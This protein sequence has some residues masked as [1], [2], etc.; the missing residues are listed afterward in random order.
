MHLSTSISS[1]IFCRLWDLWCSWYQWQGLLHHLWSLLQRGVDGAS[2]EPQHGAVGGGHGGIHAGSCARLVVIMSLILLGI[3]WSY[4]LVNLELIKS[5]WI[6]NIFIYNLKTF[7]TIDVLSKLA[8]LWI[9]ARKRVYYSQ[10]THITFICPMLF[11]SFPLDTQIC[12][13]QV[14]VNTFYYFNPKMTV[15]A[16]FTISSFI[17][18]SHLE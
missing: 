15:F 1:L 13:F 16:L 17:S 11:D 6:P 4:L 7:Q 5:L 12:K 9:D 14:E 8:G 10:A 2:P 3:S 18:S